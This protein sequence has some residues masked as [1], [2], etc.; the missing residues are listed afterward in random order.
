MKKYHIK[1]AHQSGSTLYYNEAVE[2]QIQQYFS[3]TTVSNEA[4]QNTSEA[5]QDASNDTVIQALINQL[6]IKDKQI[7]EL[8]ATIKILSESINAAHHNELAETII[9]SQSLPPPAPEK[10]SLW[11]K[12][13]KRKN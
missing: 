12:I 13:F 10:V 5:H 1:E 3:D 6:E 8:T 4:H 7:E 2:T 11:K 9:D